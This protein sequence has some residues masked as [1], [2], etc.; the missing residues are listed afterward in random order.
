MLLAAIERA[1]RDR[2]LR[3][4]LAMLRARVGDAAQRALVGRSSAIAR[5]RELVGRAAASRLPVL[6]TGEAGVGRTSSPG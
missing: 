5:V 2:Q 4:E 3:C 1:M 6:V